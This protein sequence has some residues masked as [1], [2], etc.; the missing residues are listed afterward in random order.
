MEEIDINFVGHFVGR[1]PM[2]ETLV[3]IRKIAKKNGL[4]PDDCP[5]YTFACLVASQLMR[6]YVTR[7]NIAPVVHAHAK[8][9]RKVPNAIKAFNAFITDLQNELAKDLEALRIPEEP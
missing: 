2:P 7:K 1:K 9:L 4:D 6:G 5:S 8:N 3:N